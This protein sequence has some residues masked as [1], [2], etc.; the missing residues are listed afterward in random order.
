MG[1]I[2]DKACFRDKYRSNLLRFPDKRKIVMKRSI[3]LGH[4][5]CNPKQPCPCDIF[6]TQDLCPCAGERPDPVPGEV[7]LTRHV[8][9]AGC[10]SKIGRSDLGKVLEALPSYPDPRVLVGIATGDDAGV[11]DIGGP[12]NLVQ[13]V[14]V[15]SPV[16]DDPYTY[17]RICA[18]NSVSDIY[19]MGARPVCA[20]S[21][22]GFP[23]ESLPRE[24]LIEI[25]R[26]GIDAMHEAGVSVI[27]GHSI[28]DEEIKFGFAVTGLIEG[29]GSVTN[30]G[31]R[32]GDAL[33]LTKPLGTGLISFAMQL[34]VASDE[35]TE[36]IGKSMSAL[37]R[38]ASEL[39]VR[40]GAHACTD[41]TGFSLLGHLTEMVRHSGVS[42]R[43]DLARI[44]LFAEA[45]GCVRQ[46][47]IPGAVE[48]N[49]ES[50]A[51]GVKVTGGDGTLIDLLY[52]A[53]T[54]GG[55]LVALEPA[56]AAAY[57]EEMRQRGHAATAIV[58][59]IVE[60][61]DWRIEV[62]MNEP[63]NLI[64]IYRL[65][66]R[67]AVVQESFS[68]CDR[69]PEEASCC[70]AESEDIS[71]SK[72]QTPFGISKEEPMSS[73]S[74]I[75]SEA[76]QQL[77]KVSGEGG[78]VDARTKKFVAIAL[79]IGQHCEPC[80]KHHLQSALQQGISWDEIEEIAWEAASFTG[81][82]GRMFYQ[83]VACAVK[84]AAK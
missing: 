27:G 25:L 71:S 22:V 12:M 45:L 63:G 18:A 14:D 16:V 69:P 31:A 34:G 43:I 9:K 37:N 38:D 47:I 10:A 3:A 83:E 7:K 82:T 1:G 68:C 58:G 30:S 44:P 13:T 61:Q 36:L 28:N 73:T 75:S 84:A 32:P 81:C 56:Q 60:A 24:T 15:F 64:G 79:S 48:R 35:A 72:V 49:R 40:F 46:E 53:Q 55:L 39:M 50:F 41:V 74:R 29:S 33:V 66:E 62:A 8:R 23:I 54:S 19:A 5:V 4:C 21:V 70:G 6:R 26:G 80:L 42:A 76:F 17:G 51:D 20:L 11:F 77:M 65:P 2:E 57:V 59:E 67:R 52:D 78:L